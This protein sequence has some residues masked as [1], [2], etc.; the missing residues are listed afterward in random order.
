VFL[1]LT[2]VAT[3]AVLV[4]FWR[5]HVA[6]AERDLRA[7]AE[8]ARQ[9]ADRTMVDA[10]T[11]AGLLASEQGN[12]AQAVLWFATAATVSREDPGREHVNR[13]RIRTWSR[14]VAS[15]VRALPHP[16]QVPKQLLFHPSG[17]YL[18][19]L[20]R[21]DRG[22]SSV[23][24]A[25]WLCTLWHLPDEQPVPVAWTDKPVSAAA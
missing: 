1:L 19:V 22:R 2:L 10:Q 14:Q 13:I 11:A 15:P 21:S 23:E 12:P 5:D 16:G 25:Q 7:S 9:H 6:A 8:N 18:L 20:A 3:G 24:P 17:A 4:A